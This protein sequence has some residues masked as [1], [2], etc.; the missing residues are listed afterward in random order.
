MKTKIGVAL[1]IVL[2]AGCSGDK[3]TGV[4]QNVTQVNTYLQG[5]PTWAQFSP[6]LP[7]QDPAPTGAAP[8]LAF[9]TV[10]SVTAHRQP[11]E[12]EDATRRCR[13]CARRRPT[14]SRRRRRTS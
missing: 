12:H 14:A 5:L 4:N 1:L 6:L 7:D 13:T 9:D 8:T 10:A 2:I 3:S 11:R